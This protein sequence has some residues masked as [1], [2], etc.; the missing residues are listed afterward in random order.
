MRGEE[1]MGSVNEKVVGG[2][3]FHRKH[4]GHV[5]S[6]YAVLECCCH[7]IFVDEPT[8]GCVDEDETALCVGKKT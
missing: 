1:G 6:Q 3:R 2:G 7:G 5:G 4:I 8:S